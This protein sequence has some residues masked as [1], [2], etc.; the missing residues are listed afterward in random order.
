MRLNII[1]AVSKNGGIGYKNKLPW[2]R[3]NLDMKFF[4]QITIGSKNDNNAVIMGK[5]TWLSLPKSL[6][7]R[8]NLSYKFNVKRRFCV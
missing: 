2:K 5:N 4:S 6:P 8:T 3:I 1:S 7:K